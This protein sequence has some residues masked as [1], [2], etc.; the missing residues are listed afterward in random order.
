[1][2]NLF[3]ALAEFQSKVPV[4][5]QDS[6]GYNYKYASLGEIITTITPILKAC[7]LGFTQLEQEEKLQT[8]IFETTTGESL[9]SFS[10]LDLNFV[11]LESNKKKYYYE[12]NK[13]VYYNAVVNEIRGFEGMNEQQAKGAVLTYSRRYALSCALG[14]ITDEDTDG[15]GKAQKEETAP[16]KTAPKKTTKKTEVKPKAA[17]PPP[18]P[19]K[20]PAKDFPKVL[21]FAMQSKE[22]RKK[23]F[24]S[25]DLSKKQREELDTIVFPLA[26]FKE[27]SKQFKDLL[28]EAKHSKQLRDKYLLT[29]DL[30]KDQIFN[31]ESIDTFY[32]ETEEALF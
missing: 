21:A 32:N 13:K 4:I 29:Y 18:A 22:N 5:L 30:I 31:L 27:P 15:K 25:Y 26:A 9:E 20:V 10:T 23:V 12:N 7:N 3:K 2:K 14:L 24:T 17:T 16:P 28:E 11:W 19:K 1:M 6:K 8:I